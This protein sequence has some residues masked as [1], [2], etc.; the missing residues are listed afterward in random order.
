MV[1]VI[2]SETRASIDKRSISFRRKDVV[3]NAARFAK[4]G[5]S[6]ALELQ[7]CRGMTGFL[8]QL[9][10]K[11]KRIF[12]SLKTVKELDYYVLDSRGTARS[13]RNHPKSIASRAFSLWQKNFALAN[14][15]P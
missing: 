9:F 2:K 6:D 15:M 11:S 1:V 7:M 12:M 13:S 3:V 10:D 14:K 5:S 8:D 4:S